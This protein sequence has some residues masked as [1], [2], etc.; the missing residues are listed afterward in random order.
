MLDVKSVPDQGLQ[1]AVGASVAQDNESSYG[2]DLPFS[3]LRRLDD[4]APVASIGTVSF[5]TMLK[6]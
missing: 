5:T 1:L 6:F 2:T 3:D 4:S